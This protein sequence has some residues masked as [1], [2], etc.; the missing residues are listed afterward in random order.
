MNARAVATAT[1]LTLVA[2]TSH[3]A[4]IRMFSYDPAD[5]ETRAAAGPMTFEFSQGLL[6]TTMLSVRSTEAEATVDLAPA[7][8]STLGG[9]GL[10]AM[11]GPDAAGRELYAVRAADDGAALIAALCPG[12]TRGWLAIGR[13]RYGSDLGVDVLGD[14]P[15]GGAHLCRKLA[16]N[17]HGEWRVPDAGKY[18][19]RIAA[20][21][22]GPRG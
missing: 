8:E 22:H 3:A 16:F 2:C 13:P 12:S 11:A 5:A 17:F 20:R 10:V 15:A 9:R 1:F 7:P 21:S 14:T 6:K 18:D 4:T 19:A